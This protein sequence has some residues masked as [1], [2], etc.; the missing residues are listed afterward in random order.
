MYMVSAL[1]PPIQ[2]LEPAKS[3]SFL[4]TAFAWCFLP[5]LQLRS[6]RFSGITYA[7]L[8]SLAG[9]LGPELAGGPPIA[10]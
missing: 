9:S 3:H 4:L 10:W 6:E 2:S 8:F 5:V 1:I 7:D